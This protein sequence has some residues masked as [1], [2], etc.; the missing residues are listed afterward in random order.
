MPTKNQAEQ[1]LSDLSMTELGDRL[2]ALLPY[3]L[4]FELINSN[5]EKTRAAGILGFDIGGER[6]LIPCLFLNGRIRGMEMMYLSD[7]DTFVS[8]TPQWVE[9]L[10]SRSTGVTGAPDAAGDR[11]GTVPSAALRIFN[12]EPQI[13]KRAGLDMFEKFIDL[14]KALSDTSSTFISVLKSMSK[15]AYLDFMTDITENHPELFSKI[16]EYY[17]IA[18]LEKIAQS[19]P[20]P[21]ELKNPDG[22]FKADG[23]IHATNNNNVNPETSLIPPGDPAFASE[24]AREQAKQNSEAGIAT[25]I[26]APT[27]VPVPTPVV[28]IQSKPVTSPENNLKS[29]SATPAVDQ[30]MPA[31]I[32]AIG[33]PGQNSLSAPKLA[34][35]EFITLNHIEANPSAFDN[36][37]KMA[38]MRDGMVVMDKRASCDKSELFEDDYARSFSTPSD[39]SFY[40]MINVYGNMKEI[41]VA[42]HPFNPMHPS[43]NSNRNVIVDV[44]C[45]IARAGKDVE[46]LLVRHC[47]SDACEKYNT[48]HDKLPTISSAKTGK[49][50][51]LV[52][53]NDS[54]RLISIPF[55]VQN[56]V[57]ESGKTSLSISVDSWKYGL[58]VCGGASGLSD[59]PLH[60]HTLLITDSDGEKTHA[61]GATIAVSKDWRILEINEG[62]EYSDAN[63][64]AKKQ[65]HDDKCDQFRPAGQGL[66]TEVIQGKGILELSV[67]KKQ[68]HY[69]VRNQGRTS[70][71]HTKL[72]AL[73]I[74]TAY[75]GIDASAAQSLLDG[76]EEGSQSVA[77]VKRAAIYNGMDFP[78]T[79]QSQGINELGIMEQAPFQQSQQ[80]PLNNPPVPDDWNLD[81]G[82]YDKIKKNDVDFLMRA[83]DTNSKAVFDPAMI[84]V[85]LKSNRTQ[86]QIDQWIPDLVGALD[87]LCRLLLLFYWKNADFAKSYGNDDMA[88]LEDVL[89]NNIK[90]LGTIVLFLKQRAAESSTTKIDAF[91][92]N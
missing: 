62:P 85:L 41:L 74:L 61:F 1:S 13:T 59:S 87:K 70:R 64:R 50:Y 78:D 69:I 57:V 79:D 84:G 32:K 18:E 89:L 71:P 48:F 27:P 91:S 30:I 88:E 56:R 49:T 23:V 40:S 55:K 28:P 81:A 2:P 37:T 14:E 8:A 43:K 75:V 34:A 22:S 45:G 5:D 47:K 44:E 12:R 36:E 17:D 58:D 51:M 67:H 35:L 24:V 72:G 4:G 42:H 90:N 15:K 73:Q 25:D 10:T 68:G 26:S 83:A 46:N 31:P 82:N 7:T 21:D 60:R 11:A 52:G 53:S 33:T 19:A 63:Y 77:W 66:I 9:Y 16:A 54:K 92:G 65:E 39:T 29:P 86:L 38:V 20:I 76:I 80:V 6:V 3:L